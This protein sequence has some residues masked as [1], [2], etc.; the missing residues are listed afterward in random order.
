MKLKT[1]GNKKTRTKMDK[2]NKIVVMKQKQRIYQMVKV[3]HIV[4]LN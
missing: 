4:R 1:N 3:S 2:E